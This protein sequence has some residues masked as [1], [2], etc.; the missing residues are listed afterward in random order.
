M[1]FGLIYQIPIFCTAFVLQ[2]WDLGTLHVIS[3][4]TMWIDNCYMDLYKVLGAFVQI[5]DTANVC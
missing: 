5:N 3:L 2:T 1:N 4:L